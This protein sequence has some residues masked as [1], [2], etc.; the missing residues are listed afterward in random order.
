[1]R[2]KTGWYAV[3]P[4]FFGFYYFPIFLMFFFGAHNNF[5]NDGNALFLVTVVTSV[6]LIS[7]L[8]GKL[9]FVLP[10][11]YFS[12]LPNLLDSKLMFL[13]GLVFL[14]IS[15]YFFTQ[16]GASF[17]YSGESLSESGPIPKLVTM[18]KGFF[19][20]YVLYNFILAVTIKFRSLFS[21]ITLLIHTINWML[22]ANGAVDILWILV[23]LLIISKGGQSFHIFLSPMKQ[24]TVRS[25]AHKIIIAL[26]CI[27]GICGVVF[28][29]FANKM[30]FDAAIELFRSDFVNRVLYYLYYRLSVFSSSF[31]ILLLKGIDIDFYNQAVDSEIQL[32]K[33]RLGVIFGVV[34][35]KPEIE[36]INRFNYL[37][38]FDNPR[39]PDAGA[40]PGP[41][42]TFAYFPFLPFNLLL[43]SLY[44][45]MIANTYSRVLK[46]DTG[47][48]LS[49]LGIAF[50]FVANFVFFHNP[51]SAF[52]KIGPELFRTLMFLYALGM[53][54]KI[55]NRYLER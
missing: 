5:A 12:K 15:L 48:A 51:F 20:A 14:P 30:G 41:I 26:L 34:V 42:G 4:Y 6:I 40:T 47:Y 29:G 45:S 43:C 17:R 28:F 16:Y 21:R 54:L 44:V 24:M 37:I 35:D 9:R 10:V 33:F 7:L 1:M 2:I 23:A 13:I 38:L 25:F 3:L 36:G 8:F 27:A 46:I 18:Y 49:I 19:S 11:Y 22:C 52:T 55:N 31:E 53:A 39:L 50:L 32:I